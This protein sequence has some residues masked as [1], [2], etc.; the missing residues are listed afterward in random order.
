[1]HD[2]IVIENKE[3]QDRFLKEKAL[4]DAFG[5]L[6]KGDNFSQTFKRY[7]RLYLVKKQYTFTG[8]IIVVRLQDPDRFHVCRLYRQGDKYLLTD[9]KNPPLILDEI[10]YV[11]TVIG[12]ERIF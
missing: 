11:G 4:G 3:A 2:Q 12:F 9:E 7:D 6:Y 1:M 8:E 10:D 5:L